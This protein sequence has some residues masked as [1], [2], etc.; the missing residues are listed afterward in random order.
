ID[1]FESSDNSI[2]DFLENKLKKLKS[3]EI[4]DIDIENIL[5][6][7]IAKHFKHNFSKIRIFYYLFTVYSINK[8][9]NMKS[10]SSVK[11]I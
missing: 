4:S 6:K 3:L 11:V 2:Y 5:E 7:D 9:I 8:C 1:I 10:K